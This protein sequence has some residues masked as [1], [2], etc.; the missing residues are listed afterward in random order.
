MSPWNT[1]APVESR[2]STLWGTPASLFENAMPNGW[3]AAASSAFLSKVRFDAAIW[4]VG[5]P[6][7][8]LPPGP[9][10]APGRPA[11]IARV[12]VEVEVVHLARHDVALEEELG[13]VEGVDNVRAEQRDVDGDS[14]R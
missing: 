8:G 3:P 6:A 7:A 5:P 4:M 14:G 1:T 2:M 9:G 13:D 12:D 11:G 10:L